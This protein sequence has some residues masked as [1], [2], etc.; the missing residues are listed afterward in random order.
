ML[1]KSE[2]RLII[3]RLAL[4]TERGMIYLMQKGQ[5]EYAERKA[6]ECF[7][8]WND[9]TGCF[10]K[11]SGYYYEMC[12]VIRNAVSIGSMVALDVDFDIIEGEPVQRKPIEV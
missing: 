3:S 10:E 5:K 4:A 7:D 6:L 1:R 11:F 9:V 12:S 8:A 2:T